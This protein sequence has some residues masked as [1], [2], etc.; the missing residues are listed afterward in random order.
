VSSEDNAT[1]TGPEL[2]ANLRSFFELHGL[3]GIP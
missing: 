3:P 1:A 2:Q